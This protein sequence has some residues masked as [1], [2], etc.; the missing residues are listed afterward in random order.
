M[1]IN[2]LIVEDHALFAEGLVALLQQ[3]TE[4]NI[5]VLGVSSDGC[6]AVALCTKRRVDLVFLDLNLGRVNG[7]DLIKPIKEVSP[8]TKILIV[9]GYDNQK[10]VK[11]AFLNGADGYLL[12]GSRGSNW[13]RPLK[14]S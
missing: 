8:K 12:K 9:S 6:D 7:L 4:L 13:L 3:S 11:K 14:R 10:F 2:A 5:K 1:R